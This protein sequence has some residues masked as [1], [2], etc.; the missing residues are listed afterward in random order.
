MGAGSVTIVCCYGIII[1]RS[2]VRR[3][4][5]KI[6][7]SALNDSDVINTIANERC[8]NESDGKTT[9]TTYKQL[10]EMRFY[11]YEKKFGIL[12]V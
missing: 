3:K 6:L 10:H 9:I 5:N 2:M 12:F 1:L 11:S 4:R 7:Y 8:M